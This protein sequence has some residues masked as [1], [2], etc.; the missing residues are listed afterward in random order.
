MAQQWHYLSAHSQQQSQLPSIGIEREKK[1]NHKQ[2]TG[3]TI[4]NWRNKNQTRKPFL[5]LLTNVETHAHTKY[6]HPGC[7]SNGWL[8]LCGSVWFRL[9]LRSFL[10]LTFYWISALFLTETVKHLFSWI[11]F[12]LPSFCSPCCRF[13][14][15]F[16]NE[17]KKWRTL[18]HLSRS[19]QM[20]AEKAMRKWNRNNK[21]G[22]ASRCT[23]LKDLPQPNN[24]FRNK[25]KIRI[26]PCIDS[27]VCTCTMDF[28]MQFVIYIFIVNEREKNLHAHRHTATRSLA[29]SL[30]EEFTWQN[31]MNNFKR[32]TIFSSC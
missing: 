15:H 12:L 14:F 10:L 21:Q 13:I 24:I 2:T 1:H 26:N 16:P 11:F 30:A 27:T 25:I 3:Q 28:C 7:R 4:E 17:E 6:R 23:V 22:N 9:F 29:R 5:L 19:G 20:C 18:S 32:T 8:D 31:V